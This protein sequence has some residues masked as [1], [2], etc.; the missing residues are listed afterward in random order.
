MEIRCSRG[1]LAIRSGLTSNSRRTRGLVGAAEVEE[2][3]LPAS[4]VRVRQTSPRWEA[5]ALQESPRITISVDRHDDR[6]ES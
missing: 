6:Y 4:L 5:V 1:T 3:L 2:C